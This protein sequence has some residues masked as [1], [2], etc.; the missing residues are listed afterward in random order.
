MG[1]NGGNNKKKS[2]ASSSSGSK[3]SGGK[4]AVEIRDINFEPAVAGSDTTN[5]TNFVN[6][7]S[8]GVINNNTASNIPSANTQAN[9]NTNTTA[10]TASNKLENILT[11]LE[12]GCLAEVSEDKM[13]NSA[14]AAA[15]AADAVGYLRKK[16]A[17]LGF[18]AGIQL[19]GGGAFRDA[20]KLLEGFP[21][22]DEYELTFEEVESE[23][24][25]D[26]D[27]GLEG[28][29]DE[30]CDS[31]DSLES[32]D[33]LNGCS[34]DRLDPLRVLSSKTEATVDGKISNGSSLNY[35][36][37][38]PLKLQVIQSA[39]S[40][41][42]TVHDLFESTTISA[43]QK[44]PL[45]KRKYME[46]MQ[47]DIRHR[48]ES[49]R[50]RDYLDTLHLERQ[51]VER[52]LE[53]AVNLRTSMEQLCEKLQGENSKI[54]AEK[55]GITSK[56]YGDLELKALEEELSLAS[57]SA[58]I[59][60]S[61]SSSKKSG[62]KHQQNKKA[63]SNYQTTSLPLP[64]SLLPESVK[65]ISFEVP[66]ANKLLE[67]AQGDLKARF[68]LLINLYNQRETHFL[69]VL[70]SKDVEIQMLQGHFFSHQSQI[71]KISNFNRELN[72]K[73]GDLSS[74]ESDLRSQLSIY[75]EKFKQVEDTLSKSNDLFATFRHEMEQMTTKLGRLERENQSLQS[76]CT[77]LSRNIIEMADERSKQAAA[78][79]L[80]KNQ[81]S[82]LET[83]C[84]TLQAERNAAL[85]IK[86]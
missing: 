62:K 81:K 63:V 46:L 72:G 51:V 25:F 23:E 22:D 85:K 31:L 7:L 68:Q 50:I 43:S 44:L 82:K 54:R 20:R 86:E 48:L 45:L 64:P 47:Q 41:L 59:N 56:I 78:I 1:K 80:L 29:G 19:S 69:T 42:T 74:S 49:L 3:K 70:K 35:P 65:T 15:A 2:T 32:L 73:V 37:I 77:T 10:P 24:D 17:A 18:Q 33:L 84:R 11:E 14:I 40:E 38:D 75:V 79:E 8:D 26:C 13:G 39:E 60:S 16:M 66:D 83:L 36:L 67:G 5:N 6:S 12:R 30:T 4:V 34:L 61:S 9:G 52:E 27:G 28:E 76:K 58:A 21:G 71:Q 53:K 55:A 57:S